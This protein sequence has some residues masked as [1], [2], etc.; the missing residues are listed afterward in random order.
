MPISFNQLNSF[1]KFMIKILKKISDVQELT[2]HGWVILRVL[3]DDQ[4]AEI[5]LDKCVC[6]AVYH[7]SSTLTLTQG[8]CKTNEPSFYK[9]LYTKKL[10]YINANSLCKII[11]YICLLLYIMYLMRISWLSHRF[12]SW[13]TRDQHHHLHP[14]QQRK[15][16]LEFILRF[17]FIFSINVHMHNTNVIFQFLIPHKLLR[18]WST[19]LFWQF[20]YHLILVPKILY[21]RK[22]CQSF[23]EKSKCLFTEKNS[24]NKLSKYLF[25]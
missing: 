25:I 10:S 17:L 7:N 2:F 24:F 5:G 8:S 23:L 16:K 19:T 14:F 3:V 9:D 4:C 20:I 12:S 15:H 18:F 1:E 21:S 13:L 6:L 11:Q 22:N